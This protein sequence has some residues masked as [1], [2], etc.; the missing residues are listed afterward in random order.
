MDSKIKSN[1]TSTLTWHIIRSRKT[2]NRKG[3]C[4]ILYRILVLPW[5][6]PNF[7]RFPCNPISRSLGCP[8]YFSVTYERLDFR[9]WRL[10]NPVK[11]TAFWIHKNDILDHN[12]KWHKPFFQICPHGCFQSINFLYWHLLQQMHRVARI[13]YLLNCKILISSLKTNHLSSLMLRF[14]L[15]I[16]PSRTAV[17]CPIIIWVSHPCRNNWNTH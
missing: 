17:R 12:Y 5:L 7:N 3:Q 16:L 11:T 2:F 9:N 14:Q 4:F 10:V 8:W 13:H 6:S 15:S 1:Y